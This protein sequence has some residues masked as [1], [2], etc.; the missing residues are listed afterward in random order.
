MIAAILGLQQNRLPRRNFARFLLMMF[1]I[2]CLVLRN[3]Y[4]G[5]LYQFLQSDGRH[6]TPQ[7]ISELI[8]QKYQFVMTD[9][10]L[11]V[12][13]AHPEINK[14]RNK[15]RFSYNAQ[16]NV[17]D[18]VMNESNRNAFFASKLYLMA[19]RKQ[20]NRELPYKITSE[21]FLSANVV[22]YYRKDFYLKEA[23]DLKI[24]EILPSGLI[25]KW[26][27]DNDCTRHERT[28]RKKEPTVLNLDHLCGIFYV[29]IMGHITAFF[30]F[31][32]EVYT[33]P[34]KI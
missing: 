8:E 12:L 22:L 11:D 14:A 3:I 9:A 2:F 13:E 15:I 16:T 23:V 28:N 4:Q 20:H 29:L 10:W 19:Y 32:I 34:E 31:C 24:R 26:I 27:S 25:G 30:V 7:T 1:L 18:S 5:A 21:H 33:T 6:K 17:M